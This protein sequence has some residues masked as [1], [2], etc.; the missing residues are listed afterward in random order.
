MNVQK[1]STLR[2]KVATLILHFHMVFIR[3]SELLR[4]NYSSDSN[5]LY[6]KSDSLVFLSVLFSIYIPR[7]VI[8]LRHT[9]Y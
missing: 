1:F 6:I 3:C 8:L 4:V 9:S 7:I 5:H 2:A